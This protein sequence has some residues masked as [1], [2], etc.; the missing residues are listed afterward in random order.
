MAG[1]K[2][3]PFGNNVHFSWIPCP[4]T[5]PSAGAEQLAAQFSSPAPSLQQTLQK[6]APGLAPLTPRLQPILLV[7]PA[8]EISFRSSMEIILATVSVQRGVMWCRF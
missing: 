7:L 5:L 8:Q 4:V 2:T 1:N 3:S 6:Q